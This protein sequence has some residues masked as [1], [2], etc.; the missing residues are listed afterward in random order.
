MSVVKS[1][2]L[3]GLGLAMAACSVARDGAEYFPDQPDATG[4]APTPDGG[5]SDGTPDGG[6]DAGD[7]T[8]PDSGPSPFDA[9]A[10]DSGPVSPLCSVAV[11][12]LTVS[13][14]ALSVSTNSLT[15][16]GYLPAEGSG[17][18]MCASGDAT[19][20]QTTCPDGF[21]FQLVTGS[22]TLLVR[23]QLQS[24]HQWSAGAQFL[25]S[26]SLTG[27]LTLSVL[28]PALPPS[29]PMEASFE[30]QGTVGQDVVGSGDLT[31]V[32]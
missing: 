14:Q 26:P 6:S 15:C 22:E 2:A 11:G 30:I 19:L 3:L 23:V 29:G 7:S 16:T 27:D 24:G 28:P 5:L 17:E 8:P 32:W 12:G 13:Q 4:S 25:N 18:V 31:T 20:T 21:A 10:P 9:G 1:V